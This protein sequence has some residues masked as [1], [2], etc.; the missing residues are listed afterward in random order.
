MDKL[1]GEQ[2]CIG[3]YDINDL[4]SYYRSFYTITKFLIDKN[5][6]SNAEQSRTFI[7]GFQS[8]LWNRILCHLELK[9]PDH[10]PDDHYDLGDIHKAAKHVLHGTSQQRVGYLD[11]M[12]HAPSTLSQS[13]STPSLPAMK[14]KDL[15]AFLDKFAQTL[16]KVLATQS[17][18]TP[19]DHSLMPPQTHIVNT[20]SGLCIFCGLPGH[21]ISECLVCQ[22]YIVDGKVKKNAEGKIILPSGSFVPCTI[23]GRFIKNRDDEWYKCNPSSDP[24]IFDD[25]RNL[26][27]FDPVLCPTPSRFYCLDE[28]VF[29][30]FCFDSRPVHRSTRARDLRPSQWKDVI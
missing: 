4:S 14:T 29:I 2:L 18:S 24:P 25:V 10:Y 9:F 13:K 12:S 7:R 1:I 11:S 15:T 26:D 22:A 5:C 8:D 19:H 23:P 16:I 30:Y 3:I 6:L 20:K 21:F 17:K 28:H 27:P